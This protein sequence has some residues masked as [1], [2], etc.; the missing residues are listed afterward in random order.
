MKTFTLITTAFILSGSILCSVKAAVP[1]DVPTAVVKFGDLDTTRPA[2]KQELYRRLSKAAQAV[3][4]PM[5]GAF[6]FRALVT[7]QYEAC[8]DKALTGAVARINRPEFTDYVASRTQKS[9]H[10][11][12]RLAAR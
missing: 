9:D 12:I 5:D 11:G 4:S 6:G 2:G 8:V 1:S 3:C 10:A 7:P